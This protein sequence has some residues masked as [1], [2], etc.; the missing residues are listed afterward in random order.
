[1]GIA[2]KSIINK[3]IK[4]YNLYYYI[5][6]IFI[7][8]CA[9]PPEPPGPQ[10][11][12][13]T[14]LGAFILNEGNFQ[15]GN[16][17]VDYLNARD[18]SVAKDVFKAA[19]Q[20]SIG[21][22]L[23]SGAY[24]NGRLWLVVNNSGKIE[25]LNPENG[26]AEATLSGLTSPRY[27]LPLPSGKV[28]VSDLYANGVHIVQ[29][30]NR[31]KIGFIALPGWSEQMVLTDSI[32]WVTNVRREYCYL[33]NSRT[34]QVVDSVQAGLGN[35]Q[36][37]QDYAGNIWI[38]AS[39]DAATNVNARITCW[40]RG[41]LSKRHQFDLSAPGGSSWVMSPDGRT[42]FYIWNGSVWKMDVQNPSVP[43]NPVV[44]SMPGRLYYGLAVHPD[45]ALMYVLDAVDYVSEGFVRE[46]TYSGEGVRE[47]R[48]GIIPTGM[49]FRRGKGPA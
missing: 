16:A 24:V 8:A 3:Y 2:M 36:I 7:N 15:W 33:I 6:F 12:P 1:M 31:E 42:A 9:R 20:R 35:Q 21:D 41:D 45:E 49:I 23:Q 29:A 43:G 4:Q 46:Y 34:D 11:V 26:V 37:S 38:F 5:I 28:Y 22:V 25:I 10:L 14:D 44:A 17:R 18:F 13:E 47:A 27:L 39:G 40:N 30:D 32:A 48:T 19:N